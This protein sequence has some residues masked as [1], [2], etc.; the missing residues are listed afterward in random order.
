VERI[1][2]TPLL[3]KLGI[4]PGMRVAILDVDDPD[5]RPQIAERTTDLTEGWPEPD[6]DVVLLGADSLDELGILEELATRIRPTAGSGSCR[7]RARQGRSATS[8][9]STRR[10]RPAGRQQ[11][12]RLLGHAHRHAR[13]HPGRE[14]A[15]LAE[16]AG[17]PSFA[18]GPD[19]LIVLII[20]LIVV[21]L[22]RGPKNLPKLGEAFGRGVK[23]ARTEA[24][25]AQAE[26]QARASGD[27]A[28]PPRR[29][30]A[31]RPPELSRTRHRAVK[32]SPAR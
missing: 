16:R 11:D 26:I 8:T 31:G 27:T 28:Q 32:P 23:E 22:W 7:A 10:S 5:I 2:T 18:M 14:A 12:R 13:G 25:K 21:V 19:I 20:V 6:T 24:T 4:R 1:Y 17:V 3:D 30:R 15:A 9:S 29:R